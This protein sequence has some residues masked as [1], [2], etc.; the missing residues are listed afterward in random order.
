MD[1]Q[2]EVPS[3]RSE[4]SDASGRS[5]GP[6]GGRQKPGENRTGYGFANFNPDEAAGRKFIPQAKSESRIE[7]WIRWLLISDLWTSGL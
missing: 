7:K 3:E 1:A 6:A 4:G 2:P 5:T